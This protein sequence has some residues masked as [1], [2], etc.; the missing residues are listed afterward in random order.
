MKQKEL[1][2]KA[3]EALIDSWGSDAPWEVV[4][5]CNELLDW[6][7]AEYNVSLGIRFSENEFNLNEVIE[8]IKKS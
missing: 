2:I 6:Y 4:W 3:L 5:G 7:E 1:F 8:A